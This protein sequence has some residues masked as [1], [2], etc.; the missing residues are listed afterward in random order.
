MTKAMQEMRRHG[1][2][3]TLP[4]QLKN[5][6]ELKHLESQHIKRA[7][8][9]ASL[10]VVTTLPDGSI[11]AEGGETPEM[12]PNMVY[13][14]V[15]CFQR[16]Y[17]KARVCPFSRVV[18]MFIQESGI[19]YRMLAIDLAHKPDWFVRE[20]TGTCPNIYW[21]GEW[22][23][24]SSDILQVLKKM[25]PKETKSLIQ[26]HGL[27]LQEDEMNLFQR[28]YDVSHAFLKSKRDDDSRERKLHE[29][30]E[31]LLLV[32][33]RLMDVSASISNQDAPFLAGGTISLNDIALVVPLYTAVYTSISKLLKYDLKSKFPLLYE[34]IENISERE[35]FKKTSIE[36]A[37]TFIL[38]WTAKW[39]GAKPSDPDADNYY[40]LFTPE[41]EQAEKDYIT[42]NRV[43][44]RNEVGKWTLYSLLELLNGILQN[45]PYLCGNDPGTIDYF[46]AS[47]LF[48]QIPTLRLVKGWKMSEKFP[49]VAVY[50]KR[51]SSLPRFSPAF[52][53]EETECLFLSY[54]AT[55]VKDKNPHIESMM[56][57][58][59]ELEIQESKNMALMIIE[60]EKR[61]RPREDSNQSLSSSGSNSSSKL[62]GAVMTGEFR[63]G[64]TKNFRIERSKFIDLTSRRKKG[65]RVS[66]EDQDLLFCL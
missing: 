3:L 62:I 58:I 4:S 45:S 30:E 33:R 12:L 9:A 41:L 46:F 27:P 56:D 25:F 40:I 13:L 34:Y 28:C 18:E 43:M 29:L 20:T 63:V 52:P 60:K 2:N 51:V 21:N 38:Y 16:G 42:K 35:S 47:L 50:A 1:G 23:P 7:S 59:T 48:F 10:E 24:E 37:E 65:K 22:I 15:G 64:E 57:M 54:F 26:P 14:A 6:E 66:K 32:E 49:E 31:M 5:I 55:R 36:S 53:S 17:E 8:S 11:L 61:K 19:E 44:S 39:N